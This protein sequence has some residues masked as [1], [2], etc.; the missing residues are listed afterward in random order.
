MTEPTISSSIEQICQEKKLSKEQVLAAIEQAL[1]SAYRKDFGYKMQNLKVEFNPENGK[2]KVFDEKSV[3]EDLPE[4]LLVDKEKDEKISTP[5]IET[6]KIQVESDKNEKEKPLRVGDETANLEESDEGKEKRFNP[7]TEI[8]LSEVRK[9]S[10]WENI[11]RPN[12]KIK[13]GDI[14]RQELEIPSDFGRIAAQTAK[15]VIIQ[16]LRE[17]ERETILEKY[18]SQIGAV[19]NAVVQRR[20]RQAVLLDLADASAIM[21]YN[22]QVLEE[23]YWPE[24]KIKVYLVA[25]NKTA[26]G[27]ELIVSRRHPEILRELFK[28]EI[29]EIANGTVEIKAIAREA[30]SRSKIAV[31]TTDKSV[32]PIGAAIGQRGVRIQTIINEIGGEKIDVIE[33]SEDPEKFVANAL[34]PA[35]IS[36]IKMEKKEK[37]A[38]VK[39]KKN[40]LSLAIGRAGQNVRLAAKLTGWRIDA[41]E[42]RE[43]EE[44]KNEELK[45]SKD[46]ET[47]EQKNEEIKESKGKKAKKMKDKEKK[48]KKIIEKQ[49]KKK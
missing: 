22:E 31:A 28:L 45:E 40:Q 16:R 42:D 6:N 23:K 43:T 24:Q 11:S 49:S 46:R 1:A 2:M 5:A 33:Y 9:N 39:A 20:E 41:S 37:C 30:G 38:L 27:P 35:K 19:I 4:E 29:P 12:K 36:S 44:Q 18:T 26:R 17:A 32:D 13:I 8:Q 10:N 15:Q 21:P 47:E 25:V 7:K 3:V 14:V 34:S 48:P